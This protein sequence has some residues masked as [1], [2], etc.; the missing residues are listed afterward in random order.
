MMDREKSNQ[1]FPSKKA[2]FKKDLSKILIFGGNCKFPNSF[3]N[4]LGNAWR[5][6][7]L[8]I[9]AIWGREELNIGPQMH[10]YMLLTTYYKF[11]AL[12]KGLKIRVIANFTKKTKQ[13]WWTIGAQKN[14]RVCI[15]KWL[16]KP[17]FFHPIT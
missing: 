4:M 9:Q 11:L 2:F 6:L 17:S 7:F 16:L 1:M 8:F 3:Q 10:G 13:N 12:G 14:L 5:M 15:V